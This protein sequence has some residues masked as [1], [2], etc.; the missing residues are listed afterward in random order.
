MLTE[1]ATNLIPFAGT[2]LLGHFHGNAAVANLRVVLPLAG[3]IRVIM[4]SFNVLY[5]GY[6]ARLHARD[7]HAGVGTLYWQSAAWV[8]AG[9]FPLFTVVFLAADPITIALYGGQYADSAPVLRTL[10]FASFFN[11]ALGMNAMTLR[12]VGRVRAVVVTTALS[13]A[14]GLLVALVCIPQWE[15]FGAAT[16]MAVTVVVDTGLKHFLL[17]RALDAPKPRTEGRAV[18][19][20]APFYGALGTALAVLVAAL[21]LGPPGL[22]VSGVLAAALSAALIVAWRRRLRVVESFPEVRRLRAWLRRRTGR[23]PLAEKP[24]LCYESRPRQPSCDEDP[25][26]VPGCENSSPERAAAPPRG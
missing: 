22:I 18:A 11:V 10:A 16:A 14:A 13:L 26:C 9:T 4:R 6:A 3:M 17:L 23:Q 20:R 21:M 5:T 25:A 7:D 15:A 8:A 1:L 24:D 12:A 19:S 2:V